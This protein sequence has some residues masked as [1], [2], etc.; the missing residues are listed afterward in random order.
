[1][2][3]LLYGHDAMVAN[4]KAH[5][6]W[7]AS[8]K[9]KASNTYIDADAPRPRE[10]MVDLAALA[11][12]VAPLVLAQVPK[13]PPQ[14]PFD[15]VRMMRTIAGPIRDFVG[16]QATA[17]WEN[18][19]ELY[20]EAT[21]AV[22][23]QAA[24]IGQLED[25][26]AE[27]HKAQS[28]SDDRLNDRLAAVELFRNEANVLRAELEKATNTQSFM[29]AQMEALETTVARSVGAHT[30]LLKQIEEM[31]TKSLD[32][33]RLHSTFEIKRI[34]EA[35]RV[36]AGIAS[37]PSVD[38]TGEVVCPEGMQVKLPIPL[39]WQ[40][41]HS[42]PCGSIYMAQAS[43]AGVVIEAQMARIEEDGELK[44]ITERAWTAVKN[45][46]CRG[47]SIGFS[48]IKSERMANGN[49]RWL[50]WWLNECSIVTIPANQDCG[51]TMIRSMD[52]PAGRLFAAENEALHAETAALRQQVADLEV[53]AA[54]G[55]LYKG[56][57]SPDE[58]NYPVG[59]TVTHGGGCWIAQEPTSKRPGDGDRN[60]WQLML[61]QGRTGKGAWETVR[62]YGYTGSE[63]E[64][65]E[66]L[67]RAARQG[68]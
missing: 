25:Q 32:G 60:G 22:Q 55:M 54:G 6:E 58:K 48:P 41:D 23:V 3:N 31:E 12:D 42:C 67:M 52:S 19:Q 44:S 49:R 62:K 11:A 68:K 39:L 4:M 35:A 15:V 45:R 46:L 14:E 56:V 59:S 53:R 64:F 13:V 30:M 47:L 27:M 29:L 18:N 26:L 34:D 50:T 28:A 61:K 63:A 33:V 5:P 17:I 57:W 43:P 24:L 40:H 7:F 37:T 1:M 38:K 2:S 36:I 10:L 8:D 65:A 51:I 16:E 21:K 9:R 20:A 66:A